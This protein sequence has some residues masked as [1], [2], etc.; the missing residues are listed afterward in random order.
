MDYKA[1]KIYFDR[2]R[3]WETAARLRAEHVYMESE[4]K[5]H[6]LLIFNAAERYE[7]FLKNYSHL[8][9]R[10]HQ[11]M[12]AMYLGITPVSLSRIIGGRQKPAKR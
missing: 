12:I 6:Q 11:Y 1:F 9:K 4:K 10:I 5:E 3:C 2:H 7:Y 8:Q